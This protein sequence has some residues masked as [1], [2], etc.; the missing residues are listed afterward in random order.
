[1]V[2]SKN[3][4]NIGSADTPL[5]QQSKLLLKPRAGP[6]VTVYNFGYDDKKNVMAEVTFSDSST[7]GAVPLSD[8]LAVGK[9]A[10][11]VFA[12]KTGLRS[13]ELY[14]A[15]G[16]VFRKSIAYGNPTAFT[17]FTAFWQYSDSTGLETWGYAYT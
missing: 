3:R 2:K 4:G 14:F 5:R 6:S 15:C 10:S 9:S 7:S 1:M 13:V 12:G 11:H 16:G 8:L 17:Q